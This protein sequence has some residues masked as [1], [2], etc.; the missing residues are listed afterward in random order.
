MSDRKYRS[1]EERAR[2]RA[3]VLAQ[4]DQLD[5]GTGGAAAGLRDALDEFVARAGTKDRGSTRAGRLDLTG[6]LGP[7]RALEFLLPGRRIMGHY[8]RITAAPRGLPGPEQ[9]EP[10]TQGT[11]EASRCAAGRGCR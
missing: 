8:V 5:L 7:G 6:D 2:I 11:N 1:A 10:E 3:E 9:R 4:L